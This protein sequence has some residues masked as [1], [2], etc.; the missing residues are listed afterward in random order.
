M[1]RS[2]EKWTDDEIRNVISLYQ[3]GL[4]LGGIASIH[5]RPLGDISIKLKT[6]GIINIDPGMNLDQI[7][8]F[9]KEK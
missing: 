6:L 2:G 9:K 1:S 3:C 8:S 5:H 4:T 7:A